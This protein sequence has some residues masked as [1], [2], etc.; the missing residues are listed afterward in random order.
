MAS[1]ELSVRTITFDRAAVEAI[2]AVLGASVGRADFRLPDAAV[3]QLLIEGVDGRPTTMLTL[4]PSI[5]RVDVVAG[6]ATIALTDVVAVDLSPGV[7]IVF[8]RGNGTHC[9][10]TVAGRVVVRA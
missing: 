8:R 1:H 7:E 10:V 3:H 6:P 4:W 2:G 9:V 5:R